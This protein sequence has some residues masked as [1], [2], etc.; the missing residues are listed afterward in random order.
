MKDLAIILLAFRG[1]HLHRALSSLQLQRD[2]NFRVYVCD[3]A[4][5]D[6]IAGTVS[7]F[8]DRMDLV[9]VRF[10]ENFGLRRQSAHFARCLA[11]TQGEGLVCFFS[12][13]NE[14]TPDAVRRIRRSAG[15]HPEIRVFHLNT[16]YINE[17]SERTGEGKRFFRKMKPSPL[18]RRIFKAGAPAPMSSFFFRREAL[19]GAMSQIKD[20]ARAPLTLVFAAV[21][22]EGRLLTVCRA[23]LL[24]RPHSSDYSSLPAMILEKAQQLQSFFGWTEYF[25]EEGG[26]P[27]K[28]RERVELFAKYAARQFPARSEE[29]ILEQFLR[30]RVF[31]REFGKG[32]GKRILHKSLSK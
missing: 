16:V 12:D 8:E 32:R 5:P 2:K 11:L 22:L 14:L 29:E 10:E 13:D 6:D 15:F 23:R 18:F 20:V 9:Y 19:D 30:F 25:F 7:E 24:K 3:D 1:A 28:P 26:Y 4:S 27:L 17:T 31:E 21:G